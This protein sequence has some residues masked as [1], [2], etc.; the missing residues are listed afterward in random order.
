MI[1]RASRVKVKGI[2]LEGRPK[3]YKA[4]GIL[5][6]IFQHEIDHLDGVLVSDKGKLI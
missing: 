2:T 4:M 1:R 3:T 6:Q 5:A